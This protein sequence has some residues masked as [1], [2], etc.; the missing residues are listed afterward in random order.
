MRFGSL[1]NEK[2]GIFAPQFS[3]PPH[4]SIAACLGVRVAGCIVLV[5]AYF[6]CDV[7]AGDTF[8]F[9][10]ATD[11]TH[12]RGSTLNKEVVLAQLLQ[13][14]SSGWIVAIRFHRGSV[15]R[16]LLNVGRMCEIVIR[17]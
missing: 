8:I 5:I 1:R 17:R 12:S 14:G 15:V 11:I 3:A 13:F 7:P 9:D 6:K 10:T 2:N 16:L 4:A